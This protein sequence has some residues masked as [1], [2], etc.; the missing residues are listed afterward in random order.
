MFDLSSPL[1]ASE[2]S[3][4]VGVCEVG[5]PFCHHLV[6]RKGYCFADCVLLLRVEAYA[7]AAAMWFASSLGFMGS[8][9]WLRALPH[10]FGLGSCCC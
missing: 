10:R 9:W 6:L 7:A 3:W 4:G 1:A 2:P 8:L 5:I